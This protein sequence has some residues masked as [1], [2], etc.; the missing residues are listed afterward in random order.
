M[1]E[2]EPVVVP[3]RSLDPRAAA[4]VLIALAFVTG[5]L[6]G[7]AGD[8]IYLLRSHRFFPERAARAMTP[9]L[10]DRLEKE[11]KLTPQ[12]RHEV[13]RILEKR[14]TRIESVWTSVRPQ[15]DREMR[16]TNAE[17][18]KILTPEQQKKFK[19]MHM[20]FARRR[21]PHPPPPDRDGPPHP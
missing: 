16:E 13:T 19:E 15:V 1:S 12:Q 6:V 4:I 5:I 20:R 2:S 3:P 14:R 21:G 17:I 8:R 10:V 11:L 7:I 9:R 18:A